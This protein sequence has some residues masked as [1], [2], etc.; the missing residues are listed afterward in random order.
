MIYKRCT[1]PFYLKRFTQAYKKSGYEE[2]V[3]QLSY[4]VRVALRVA[5]K[6][7]LH[8]LEMSGVL[9]PLLKVRSKELEDI[10][11]K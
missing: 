8:A 3:I 10:W 1:I 9:N 5:E 11:L 4:R 2:P 6:K 7:R